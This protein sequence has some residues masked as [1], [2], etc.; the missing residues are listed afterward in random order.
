MFIF[1]IVKTVF[2][3]IEEIDMIS[4]EEE[5][6][7]DKT[8]FS[9]KNEGRLFSMTNT[10]N[11]PQGIGPLDSFS[12]DDLHASKVDNFTED[13]GDGSDVFPFRR[14]FDGRPII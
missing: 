13:S 10:I 2:I 12:G 6:E 8:E 1:W 7:E 5:E 9:A 3:S 14:T 4:E 11:E